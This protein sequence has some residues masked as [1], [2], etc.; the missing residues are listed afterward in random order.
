MHWLSRLIHWISSDKC[1]FPLCLN[2]LIHR[3][4]VERINLWPER[5][6][7]KA[8]R[9]LHVEKPLKRC[10]FLREKSC[11]PMQI[12]G[13]L[14]AI[15]CPILSDNLYTAVIRCSHAFICKTT[16]DHVATT[17]SWE[18]WR[19]MWINLIIKSYLPLMTD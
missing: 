10:V 6:R 7:M 16:F 14:V 13:H 18:M 1:A 4:A 3:M 12:F 15:T 9:T 17:V 19:K 11:C 8:W 2:L 5:S